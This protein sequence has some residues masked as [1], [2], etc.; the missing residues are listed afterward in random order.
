[1]LNIINFDCIAGH[2]TQLWNAVW[3]IYAETGHC[4]LEEPVLL[5]DD[6]PISSQWGG[7]GTWGLKF[8]QACFIEYSQLYLPWEVSIYFAQ[9]A[10]Y[11]E[12]SREA[13]IERKNVPKVMHADIWT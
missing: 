3:G 7:Q 2:F 5:M 12:W 6:R 10:A 8:L 1:L 11:F 4:L 9:P 13:K